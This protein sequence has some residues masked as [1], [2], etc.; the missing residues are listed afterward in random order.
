[1]H[2]KRPKAPA[3]TTGTGTTKTTASYHTATAQSYQHRCL[4]RVPNKTRKRYLTENAQQCPN[5]GRLLAEA[6]HE[7]NTRE[8]LNTWTPFFRTREINK[9]AQRT[10]VFP[11]EVANAPRLFTRRLTAI[12]QPMFGIRLTHS[13]SSEGYL[14]VRFGVSIDAAQVQGHPGSTWQHLQI[15]PEQMSC[16]RRTSAPGHHRTPLPHTDTLA[17]RARTA[18]STT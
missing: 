8:F 12:R 5:L 16:Q 11:S 7:A 4:L 13:S 18:T 3:K 9:V 15:T 10:H 2:A 6:Q 17:P 14:S 1:M